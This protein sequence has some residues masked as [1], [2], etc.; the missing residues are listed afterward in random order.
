MQE[1][2]RAKRRGELMDIA[3]EVLVER[4]YRDTTMLEVAKRASASKETL[5][6]WFGDKRGLFE[7]IIRRNAQAVQSVL[8]NHLEEHAPTERILADFGCAL[9][10]LLL[11]DS[12]IAINRAAI[13][14]ARSDP[15]LAQTLASAGREATLPAFIHF[16]KQ[17]R[18]RGFLAIESPS[19][20]ADDFLGL[21][22]GDL[23]TRRL[24]GVMPTPGKA[25]IQSKAARAA[26]AFLALYKA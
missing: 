18:E 21:L 9:L 19:D 5:Y 24:L 22:L 2:S 6:V 4:G 15:T 23:Q 7:A 8:A 20:A 10:A 17:H 14:E 16:L 1:A 26:K 13:S 3:V 25:Q 12:A 11:G